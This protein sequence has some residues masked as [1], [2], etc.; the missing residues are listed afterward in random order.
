MN[1][2]SSKMTIEELQDPK[3]A[4][5]DLLELADPSRRQIELY[6]KQGRCFV[7]KLENQIAGVLVL[8]ELTPEKLEV[9]NVAI[10]KVHQGKGYGKKMLM[11]AKEVALDSGYQKLM[12]ATGNSS[13][14]QL[15]L[16]QKM[17]FEMVEIVKD[18]FIKNYPEP[19]YENG[20]QCKHQVVLEMKL[21]I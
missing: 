10:S 6:L 21:K 15:A 13:I 14:G 12:I 2:N 11:L 5:F 1:T 20:I 17:G 3:D 7:L 19:I 8:S 4:P 9:K 16:Y 18:H